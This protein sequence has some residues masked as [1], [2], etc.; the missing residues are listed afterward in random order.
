MSR[1]LAALAVLCFSIGLIS[2]A[3]IAT[4]QE[5]KAKSTSKGSAKKAKSTSKA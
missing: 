4:G 1:R 2:Y 3:G 5:G